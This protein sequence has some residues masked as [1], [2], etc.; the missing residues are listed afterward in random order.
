M[1]H[2]PYQLDTDDYL[3]L[4]ALK[5]PKWKAV[6]AVEY[7]AKERLKKEKG[8]ARLLYRALIALSENKDYSHLVKQFE[9]SGKLINLAEGFSVA[10]LP[11]AA[12][13]P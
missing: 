4:I 12:S 13:I 11:K 1:K 3:D 7:G 6:R 9:A 10:C 5:L 8:K 2:S